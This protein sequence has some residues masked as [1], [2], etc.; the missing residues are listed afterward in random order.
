MLRMLVFAI[1]FCSIIASA[2]SVAAGKATKAPA[3]TQCADPAV[4]MEATLVSKSGPGMGRVRISGTAKNLG[5]TAWVPTS[6]GQRLQLVLTAQRSAM[7][8]AGEPVEPAV[9]IAR[10]APGQQFKIDHQT[11]W[12]TG[13]NQTFPK[14]RIELYETGK[15]GPLPKAYH[16]DCQSKN[17]S[18]EI[19]AADID[20]L[21]QAP[22]SA[23]G[24]LTVHGYHLFS[25]GGN[26]IVETRLAY[27]RSSSG[28]GRL[29]ASVAAPY[30]GTAEPAPISGRSGSAT[31]RVEIPCSQVLLNHVSAPLTITYRLWG[32]LSKPGETSSW[33]GSFST[34][35]AISYQELCPAKAMPATASRTSPH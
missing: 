6:S 18:K 29:T 9:E 17:N 1:G 23:A 35:H 31:I 30:V 16:P 28:A 12:E 8:S 3:R 2:M 15:R 19:A 4:A 26:T 13:M 21:F 22:V 20:S 5:S 10:L 24:P 27:Q 14:F 11:N 25:A 33:V 32:S 7:Q 34:A